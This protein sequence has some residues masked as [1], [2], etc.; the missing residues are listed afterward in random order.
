MNKTK[1][2][3]DAEVPNQEQLV[4]DLGNDQGMKRK[5]ARKKLVARGTDSIGVLTELVD[6]PKQIL[7]WEALKS[8]EEIGSPESIPVFINALNNDFSGERWIAAKGLVRIGRKSLKPILELVSEK[9][10]SVFVLSGAHHV[11]HD[12]RE[13]DLL[14]KGFPTK[15]M[16]S[17]LKYPGGEESLKILVHRTLKEVKL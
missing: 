9:S 13:K 11:I 14:P 3:K 7:R 17:L 2:N 5:K 8:L 16:L 12:L 15:K 10:D 6:N 1:A 4:K